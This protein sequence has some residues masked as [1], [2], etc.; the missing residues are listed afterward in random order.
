VGLFLIAK[1]SE[2]G[3]KILVGEIKERITLGR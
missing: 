1:R 2:K 3:N